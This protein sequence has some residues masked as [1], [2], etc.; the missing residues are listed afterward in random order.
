MLLGEMV[1]ARGIGTVE[2]V[3]RAL[4]RQRASGG[5]L[6]GHLIA[7][8][9]LTSLELSALLVEQ[10]DARTMSPVCKQSLARWEAE[11][12]LDHPATAW[13]RSNLA[14]TLLA[15]GQA[16]EALAEA[17]MAV[18]ALRAACG[19]DHAWTKDAESV[20]KAAHY[21]VYGPKAA[22]LARLRAM[23]KQGEPQIA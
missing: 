6:G 4:E 13:S 5:H 1:V 12:G 11:F 23:T 17:Q 2:Q 14:K 19:D 8:G 21:V 22:A 16:E 10:H 7:L 3:L 18:N 20:R 15:D 9:V